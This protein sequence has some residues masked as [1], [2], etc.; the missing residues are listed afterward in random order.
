MV[1]ISFF[2]SL[3]AVFQDATAT[4]AHVPASRDFESGRDIDIGTFSSLESFFDLVGVPAANWTRIEYPEEQ[5]LELATRDHA[6]S[7]NNALVL[8]ARQDDQCPADLNSFERFVCLNFPAR[9]PWWTLGLGLLVAFGPAAFARWADSVALAIVAGRNLAQTYVGNPNGGAPGGTLPAPVPAT[10]MSELGW[11]GAN[12]IHF[13]TSEY[14]GFDGS[15]VTNEYSYNMEKSEIQYEKTIASYVPDFAAY[16]AHGEALETFGGA[17]GVQA[18]NDFYSILVTSV[19][20]NNFAVPAGEQGCLSQR[21]QDLVIQNA[22]HHRSSCTLMDNLE[23]R[24]AV[25]LGV[26]ISDQRD[27]AGAPRDCC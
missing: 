15:T 22:N 27:H 26:H 14:I 1:N 2:I 5:A 8:R 10:R 17:S 16:V 4:M 18:R 20:R 23:A 11:E 9:V 12:N 13:S 3:M 7:V 24:W 6:Y 19:R 25:A 21:I